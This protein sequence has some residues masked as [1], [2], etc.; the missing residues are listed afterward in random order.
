[1]LVPPDSH[2]VSA[3]AG[4]IGLGNV[5]EAEAELD[6]LSAE[7]R[8]DPDVLEVQWLIAAHQSQWE[9]GLKIARALLKAAPDRPTGWL[10]RAYAL[11]RV[12]E[13]GVKAAKEALLPASKKFPS[14]S[15]IPY[16]LACY[17]CQLNDLD[18]ARRW[19]RR[20]VSSAG[21]EVVKKMALEDTDLELLHE[22]IKRM[23]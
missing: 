15:V 19:L 11:R 7:A 9:R 21:L 18:G 4:W 16:N 12:P 3:A 2:Y 17:A 5:K 13:G 10:H 23:Q 22:E 1:M 8:R 6:S 14:E 20:A